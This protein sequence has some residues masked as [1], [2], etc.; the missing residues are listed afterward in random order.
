MKLFDEV[1][2]LISFVGRVPMQNAQ[3]TSFLMM[4]IDDDVC[5]AASDATS[6]FYGW[7]LSGGG[8]ST[9]ENHFS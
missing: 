7:L 5:Q 8:L 9:F 1:G 2:I 6:F 3:V 4:M